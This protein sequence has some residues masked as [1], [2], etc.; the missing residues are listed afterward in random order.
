MSKRQH[1]TSFR[2]TQAMPAKS[3]HLLFKRKSLCSGFGTSSSFPSA[4]RGTEQRRNVRA[5]NFSPLLQVLSLCSA[6]RSATLARAADPQ[7]RTRPCSCLRWPSSEPPA[8][9]EYILFLIWL[10]RTPTVAGAR[11]I[12]A[13]KPNSKRVHIGTLK[14]IA[15][16]KIACDITEQ[17]ATRNNLGFGSL[18]PMG[19]GGYTFQA[20]MAP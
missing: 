7:S 4:R 6:F 10:S 17:R 9:W 15:L 3:N 8:A 5:P 1:R 13:S 18:N 14:G 2:E 16:P 20:A 12:I 19:V 11:I